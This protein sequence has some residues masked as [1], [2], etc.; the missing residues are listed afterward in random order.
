MAL[1]SR[2]ALKS[3]FMR[4]MVPTQVNFEDLIDSSINKID[5]GFSHDPNEGFIISAQGPKKK[6]ISFYENMRDPNSAFNLSLNPNRHSKGLSFNT[7][8]DDEDGEKEK[9]VLFLRNN[10]NVGIRTT[11]PRFRLEVNGMLGHVGRVGTYRVGRKPANRQW[12]IVVGDLTGINAFEIIAQVGG[13]PGRGKYAITRAVAIAAHGK[14]SIHHVKA[15]FGWFWQK[16]RFRWKG[17]KDNYRLEARTAGNYGYANDETKEPIKF[18]FYVSKLW[19]DTS[20][21]NTDF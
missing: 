5:D 15:S 21:N 19:D 1:L 11:S 3:L 13:R 9:S 4:G 16:I 2:G 8:I 12:Q 18:N 20:M 6:L 17:D 10:G 14:G 7:L